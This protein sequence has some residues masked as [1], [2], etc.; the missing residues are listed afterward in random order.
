MITIRRV[1]FF[2]ISSIIIALFV[3]WGFDG[4]QIFT[5][6]Y[7]GTE[8]YDRSTGQF[9]IETESTFKLGL[10]LVLTISIGLSAI[11]IVLINLFRVWLATKE[12]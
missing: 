5:S 3:R 9:Y 11:G 4:F 12:S 8:L 7:P 6:F 1:V 10:D 2:V